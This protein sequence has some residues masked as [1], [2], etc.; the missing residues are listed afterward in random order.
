MLTEVGHTEVHRILS[1]RTL[2]FYFLKDVV[3]VNEDIADRD[4]CVMEHLMSQESLE[5]LFV[6]MK[7]ISG[8]SS[9]RA[10]VVD[11]ISLSIDL[12][13]FSSPEDFIEKQKGD[14]YL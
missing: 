2:M 14:R 8:K 12:S 9:E 1:T 13:S 3:G 7:S 10:K 5:N 11:S 6:F 4:S